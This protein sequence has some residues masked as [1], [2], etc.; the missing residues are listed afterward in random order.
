MDNKYSGITRRKLFQSAAAFAIPAIVPSSVLGGPRHFSPGE[1][2][3][4]GFIGTGK[5]C[6]DYHLPSLLGF[7]D[8]HALAVCDVDTTRRKAAKKF[9]E[10]VY[11]KDNPKYKGCDAYNDFRDILARDDID[12]VL[13]ATP[14]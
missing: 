3:T 11:T 9:V 12:A 4:V 10:D 13:I 1:K 2:I 14:E 5:M 6:F 7:K 8:V